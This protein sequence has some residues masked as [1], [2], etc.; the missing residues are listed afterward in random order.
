MCN[1]NKILKNNMFLNALIENEKAE[2]N[3]LFC[4]HNINHFLDT[5]RIAYILSLENNLKIPKDN[6]Y[7]ASLL[8][9]I[10][11]FKQYN[12]GVNHVEASIIL[13]KEILN[14][15]GYRKNDVDDIII[16]IR[17]HGK[18]NNEV[19]SLSD[20]IYLADKLSRNCFLCNAIN[21]CYWKDEEK[22]MDIK[23]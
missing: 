20:I 13:T 6:I 9:D 18:K 1:Y 12:E 14:D 17:N 10:G 23:Y 7:A 21:E 2:K 5:A 19:K 4:L 22:N 3:R 8:H 15:C 16:A 11:R